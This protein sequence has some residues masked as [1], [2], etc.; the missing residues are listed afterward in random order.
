MAS[1]DDT[2]ELRWPHGS[3]RHR[4]CR[5]RQ[6]RSAAEDLRANI[7]TWSTATIGETVQP[8]QL[9]TKE[10]AARCY[11]H[12]TGDAPA[13]DSMAR[14][15]AGLGCGKVPER[16]AVL[17]CT[18]SAMET[19]GVHRSGHLQQWLPRELAW[20]LRQR[21]LPVLKWLQL[22]AEHSAPRRRHH[23]CSASDGAIGVH[24]R[25]C[26]GD[27]VQHRRAR[28]VRRGAGGRSTLREARGT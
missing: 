10:A 14:P 28:L 17:A 13:G 7:R 12:G 27:G 16:E 26:S 3:R 20:K 21:A 23:H 25:A 18:C 24:V 1:V 8:L 9:P 19:E 2:Q 15:N 6:L 5:C 11:W 22:A 4:C